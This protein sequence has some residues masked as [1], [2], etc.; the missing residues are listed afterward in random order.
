MTRLTVQHLM[1]YALAAEAHPGY[2][3]APRKAI[4]RYQHPTQ[5]PY[6]YPAQPM[7]TPAYP[8]YGDNT[9]GAEY[10]FQPTFVVP[11]PAQ[12]ANAGPPGYA[13]APNQ[14]VSD[15]QTGLGI[16]GL[17][18]YNTAGI[19]YD[20]EDPLAM[21]QYVA[22]EDQQRVEVQPYPMDIRARSQW[23]SPFVG[24][25]DPY[26]WQQQQLQSHQP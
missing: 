14:S 8:V 2:D 26:I 22:A 13:Y 4:L 21:Q 10:P 1:F 19:P 9:P 7:P 11:Q 17:S 16:S 3:G 18:H 25:V 12:F 24:H 15:Y 5:Q 6:S 23:S 20:P